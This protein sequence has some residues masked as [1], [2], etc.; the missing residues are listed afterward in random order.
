MDYIIRKFKENQRRQTTPKMVITSPGLNQDSP[1]FDFDLQ[2]S[3][4]FHSSPVRRN[5]SNHHNHRNEHNNSQYSLN[6]SPSR[7]SCSSEDA[8]NSIHNSTIRKVFNNKKPFI[9]VKSFKLLI[10][11]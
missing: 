11:K 10:Q 8:E 7:S 4:S 9:A 1:H 3:L 6:S 2:E 5:H